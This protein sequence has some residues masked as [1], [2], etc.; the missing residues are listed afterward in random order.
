KEGCASWDL[1]KGTWGGQEKGFGTVPVWCRCTGSGVGD[2]VVLAGKWVEVTV[3]VVRVLGLEGNDMWDLRARSH[4]DVGLAFGTVPVCV[5]AHEMAGGEGRVLVGKGVGD[6]LFAKAITTRSGISY[7]GPLI[8]P[9]G[10]EKESEVTKDTE[11]PSIEDIQPP[12]VQVPEKVQEPIDEPFVVP[13]PKA[14][15]PYPSRLAKEKL[16][17]KDD[18]LAAKFMEIFRDLH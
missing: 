14:N 8:P 15:L 9:P 18:I 13:K 1:G 5:C 7:D 11:L 12:S 4:E 16:R 2:G 10:V 6:V 3:W 17:E